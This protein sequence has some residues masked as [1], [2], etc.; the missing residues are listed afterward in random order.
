MGKCSKAE[1]RQCA[2]AGENM[3]FLRNSKKSTWMGYEEH[4]ATEDGDVWWE[5][6]DHAKS[7]MFAKWMFALFLRLEDT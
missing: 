6:Q 3:L 4:G 2:K 7:C 1:I 5:G